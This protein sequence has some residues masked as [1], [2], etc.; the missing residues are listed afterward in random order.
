MKMFYGFCTIAIVGTFTFIG[1]QL[2]KNQE[3][4]SDDLPKKFEHY[5]SLDSSRVIKSGN[6]SMELLT[7]SSEDIQYFLTSDNKLIVYSVLGETKNIF[8]KVDKKGV[9]TDSLIINCQPGDIAFVKG[10]IIN[11]QTHQFYKWTFDEKKQPI[12]IALQNN[13]LDWDIK[14][15][16]ELYSTIKKDSPAVLVDFGTESP[17]PVKHSGGEMQ[18]V[19]SM[20]TY[21]MLT[22][23]KEGECYTFFTTLDVHHQFPYS[24]TEQLLL[25]NPF[26]RINNKISGNREIIKTPAIRYRY[27]QKLKLEKVRFSGGG[28]NAPGFDEMLFH[29]NLYTDVAYK[30]DTL[31]L[32]E[33]MYLEE[34]WHLSQIEIDGKNI[35]TVTKNKSQP[36]HNIDAYMYY[37][38]Q[39]LGYALFANDDKKIYLIK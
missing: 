37:T 19:P 13:R 15:Q 5:Q 12:N 23:F 33:F 3:T 30:K 9:V 21:A 38:N 10:Y 8:H 2:F 1:F 36:P 22:Y 25:N 29:G 17:E 26:K 18:T 34:K 6:I 39:Q 14:K 28:G 7:E 32:K 11:K 24:Y 35:G 4:V 31:K 27:F 16:Q 20:R